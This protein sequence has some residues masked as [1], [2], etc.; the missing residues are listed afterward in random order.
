MDLCESVFK[1]EERAVYELRSLYRRYG[2]LPYKMSKFEEYD[3]YVRNKDFLISDNIITFTDTDGKLMALKPDVT[4]SIIKNTGDTAGGVHK[5]C[6]DE[7][8]YRITKGAGGFRELMQVGLECIGDIDSYGIYEVLMLAAESLSR[9]SEEYVL[10]IS[11]LGILS[12]IIDASGVSESTKGEL[13]KKIGEKNMHEIDA[14]CNAEG[15]D[16]SAIKKLVS[17]YGAPSE[18]LPEIKG[19][20]TGDSGDEFNEFESILMLLCK[21]GYKD[22]IRIDFSVVN[23]MN[24]YNGVVFKGF[25]R[26]IASGVLSGGQYDKLMQKMGRSACAIGFA[27]YM[28]MLERFNTGADEYDVDAMLLYDDGCDINALSDAVKL[29]SAG[30][31]SVMVQKVIP[32][33]I[34]Y[35]QL[36]KINER[37]VEILENNE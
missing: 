3:L 21:N 19:M 11:H 25:V 2:Y 28:D 4:L 18:V 24:Y 30:G 32:D 16:P 36:L 14:L 23:D 10:D 26:G 8:V 1:Y 12:E 13:L 17:L 33:K 31:K 6:Y 34:K 22:N 15:C 35:K 20:L 37:G 9:I 5:V 27:V 29:F 7:N